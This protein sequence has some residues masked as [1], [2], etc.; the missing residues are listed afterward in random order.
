[1][2]AWTTACAPTDARVKDLAVGVS[3]DSVVSI[4][5]EEPHQLAPYLIEGHYIEAMYYAKAGVTPEEAARTR[6]RDMTPVLVLDGQ[7]SGWGWTYWD[8]LATAYKIQLP[9]KE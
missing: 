5:G 8:S 6:P 9:A 2:L 3:K 7:V 4:M 1:M